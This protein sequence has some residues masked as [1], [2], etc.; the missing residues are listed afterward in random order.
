MNE[1][2]VFRLLCESTRHRMLS[3]LARSGSATAGELVKATGRTQP[4]VSHHLRVLK[5]AGVVESRR[6][7]RNMIYAIRGKRMKRAIAAMN[8]SAAEAARLCR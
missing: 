1:A 5:D 2:G 8:K 4:L 6:S 7:G 3:K